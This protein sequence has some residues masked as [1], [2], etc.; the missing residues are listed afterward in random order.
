ME[1]MYQFGSRKSEM[2]EEGK[3]FMEHLPVDLVLG[4]IT[5]HIKQ[6]KD[7]HTDS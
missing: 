6:K 3:G 7:T 1:A 2:N 5:L 4:K